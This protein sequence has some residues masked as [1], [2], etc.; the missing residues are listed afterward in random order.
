MMT[1]REY[2]D[3][4]R[5]ATTTEEEYEAVCDM[6]Q[7]LY[8]DEEVDYEEWAEANGVDLSAVDASTGETVFTLWCWDMCGE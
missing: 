8:D 6:E 1:I 3:N 5:N 2:F 4:L 7:A